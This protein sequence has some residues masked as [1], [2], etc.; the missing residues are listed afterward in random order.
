M[1]RSMGVDNVR[2]GLGP[3]ADSGVILQMYARA[4]RRPRTMRQRIDA[5]WRS[6]ATE[7]GDFLN[8]R[9]PKFPDGLMSTGRNL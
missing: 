2:F 4:G 5:R 3:A 9:L 8:G 6:A 1:R 7:G